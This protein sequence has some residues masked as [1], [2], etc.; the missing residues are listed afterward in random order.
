MLN[1]PHK[2]R[3]NGNGC[4]S[5]RAPLTAAAMEYVSTRGSAPALDFQGVT[6]AGLASCG[7]KG[8]VTDLLPPPPPTP[9]E[10]E[11]AS[12]TGG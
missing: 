10:A 8:D 7:R 3:A 12:G 1:V 9:P 6:L 5:L 11:K 2:L 4:V